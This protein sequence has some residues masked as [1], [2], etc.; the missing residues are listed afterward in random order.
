MTMNYVKANL[1][2]IIHFIFQNLFY[3]EIIL[4]K[5]CNIQKWN[6]TNKTQKNWDLSFLKMS[7]NL[8]PVEILSSA[9]VYL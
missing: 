1:H 5:Q 6:D 8:Q 7:L 3:F 4:Y 9:W 2:F